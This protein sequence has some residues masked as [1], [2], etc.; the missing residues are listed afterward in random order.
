MATIISLKRRIQAARNVSKTTRAMQMISASKLKRA[1]DAAF[2]ARPYVEKLESLTKSIF[3]TIDKIDF[4]H[5]YINQADKPSERKLL[6]VLA[7]DKGLAGSLVTNLVKDF[8]KYQKE[9]QNSS[10][11]A[12]GK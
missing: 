8:M 2:A 5:P 12:I 4:N 9:N 10:Y 3:S 1:Q 7:P 6:I 11:V